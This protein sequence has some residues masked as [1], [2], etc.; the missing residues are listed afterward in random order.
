MVDGV[1]IF[2]FVA[3]L[4]PI[5]INEALK[6]NVVQKVAGKFGVEI[7]HFIAFQGNKEGNVIICFLNLRFIELGGIFFI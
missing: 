6:E 2:H 7:N 1:L 5:T 4:L 3:G